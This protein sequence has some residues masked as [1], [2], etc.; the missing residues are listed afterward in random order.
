VKDPSSCA[1]RSSNS[2]EASPATTPTSLPTGGGCAARANVRWSPR[3][4]GHR[5][6]RLAFAMLR[7]QEPY[8]PTRWAAAVADGPVRRTPEAGP[9]ERRDPPPPSTM[10]GD[11]STEQPLAAGEVDG[12]GR[13]R[14]RYSYAARHRDRAASKTPGPSQRAS[15]HVVA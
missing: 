4:V 7:A 11:D 5:A 14:R 13:D 15:A 1:P 8:D 6:H 2:V 9:P 3:S 10:T 12:G